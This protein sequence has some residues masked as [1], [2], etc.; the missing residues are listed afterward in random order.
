MSVFQFKQFKIYQDLAGMKVGTDSI[1]LGSTIKIKSKYKHIIDVGTGTGLLSLMIAQKSSNSDI[2][3][4]EID[5][6]AFHQAK[7]NIDKCKWRNRINLIHADA[8]QLEID[9]KYDLIICNPPYFSNS[10]QSIITSKNTA[11]HQVELTFKD[12]LNIW[13]KIGNDDSD[14]AC[15]TPIIE[16]EILYK[17]VKNHGNYL[18]YYLKV[19]SNPNSNPKRAVMLFSKNKMK[20][21]K[22][23]LCIHNNEGGYSEAY[24][25][26]TKDFYLNH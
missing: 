23:E 16:S 13:D 17:M 9:H 7:I 21:I 6:N 26:M 11:R 14:L 15:I 1:I 18:A 24:I 20:T 8:K 19:Q 10:K 3:A 12:L 25:N 4:V 22:S 2:T 5:S